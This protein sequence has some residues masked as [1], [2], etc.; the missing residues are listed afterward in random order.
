MRTGDDLAALV[1]AAAPPDLGDG[2]VL[3][4]AHKVV[5]KAEGRVR[6]ARRRSSRASGRSSW[7][8][9][10]ART[11]GWC[12]PCWTSRPSCCAP[13][14]ACSSATTRHGFVCANAGVDQSNASRPGELILLPTDPDESARRLR[15]R[16]SAARGVRPAIV[17]ADSFGRPW[18]LGQTDVAHR[19]RRAGGARRLERPAGRLR[20]R[21]ARDAR[22]PSPTPR[23]RPPTWPAPR[24][25][26]ARPCWCAAWSATSRPRT[27]PARRCCGE[28][29]SRTCSASGSA[30]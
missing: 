15:A 13:A 6:V 4:I 20:P 12:R 24:T 21:A 25:R 11:P 30:L 23:P 7:R 3:V 22:S 5:S 28:R 26:A 18:R 1:A 17:I 2:D 29:P 27:G 14:T 9:S 19:R 10:T 8:R 16:I